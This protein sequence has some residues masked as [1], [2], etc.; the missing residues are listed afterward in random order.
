LE[1]EV[2]KLHSELREVYA[3]KKDLQDKINDFKRDMVC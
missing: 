3:E 1:N 2:E